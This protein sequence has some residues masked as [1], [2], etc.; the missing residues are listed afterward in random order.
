[1]K[2]IFFLLCLLAC[3]AC[4]TN[5]QEPI[6]RKALVM[7][8]NPRLTEVDSLGSLSIGNGGFAMTVDVTGLQTFPDAY[9]HGMPLGTQ[10]QWGWHTFPNVN[11]Y[12]FEET[13]QDYDFGRGRMEPYADQHP[14]FTQRRMDAAHYFRS[15]PNRLHL[16]IIGLEFDEKITVND[17]KSLDQHLNLWNGEI[18]SSFSVDNKKVVVKTVCHPE[19]DMISATVGATITGEYQPAVKFRFAY[20]TGAWGDY[21]CD[22]TKPHL[23]KTTVV[24]QTSQSAILKREINDAVYFVNIQW[25]GEATFSEK[26]KHY[27]VLSTRTD[28]LVFSAWFTPEDPSGE[29]LPKFSEIREKTANH[30]N[31]FWTKGAAVDFSKCTDERAKELERRVVLSQYLLAIQSS[32]NMP[33]QESGLTYNTWF[34]KP[35]IEM[36]YWHQAWFALWGHPEMLERS[37]GWY[38]RVEPVAKAIAER[39]GFKGIRWMKMTDHLGGEAPSRVGSFIIWQQPHI[40][41]FAELLY[42]ANPSP[43]LLERYADLIEK[44]A[45]FMYDFADYDQANDRYILK[46]IIPAQETLKPHVTFNSPY[47]LAYW[48]L[49]MKLAQQWRERMGK[50]RNAD[51]DHLIKKLS[52]LAQ[53]D[54]MYLAAESA[55]DTYEN[56][57]LISDH[58]A[59]LGAFGVFPENGLFDK[60][61]MKNTLDWIWENWN[62]NHTWGWDYPMVA[63]SAARLGDPEKAVGALLMDK[64][65]NTYLIN[66]HNYQDHVLRVYL[67]GN[68][69]L[70]TAVAMMCAGWDGN[71]TRNPGFPKDGKW[72]VRWEGLKPKI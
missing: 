29:T 13:L 37:L 16:G 70:L 67:P 60:T 63:M 18:L 54:G 35:H 43:E 69:G 66:G 38:N 58:P 51:W 52:P 64:R 24:A 25:Q 31:D 56:F 68:G 28:D 30:W 36:I 7:R 21:A 62:W 12:T 48:H 3:V 71:K 44:T 42:R 65:T 33:P 59:V 41:Y 15:N 19:K 61:I 32:A 11:N 45:E 72:D 40:I 23:H 22:W 9:Q 47:E 57:R 14:D 34:G 27:F 6:D 10:S 4:G 8:N 5:K 50:S 39:Q 2:N 17:V 26:E 46:G 20:P 1:M 55:P 49:G 53:K